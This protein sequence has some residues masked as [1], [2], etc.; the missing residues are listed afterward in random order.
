MADYVNK[1]STGHITISK[2][3]IL[4]FVAVGLVL[5]QSFHSPIRYNP[6]YPTIIKNAASST[7][8][9]CASFGRVG[10]F[11]TYHTNATQQ[12]DEFMCHLNTIRNNVITLLETPEHVDIKLPGHLSVISEATGSVEHE[13]DIRSI[14]QRAAILK[15][16]SDLVRDFSKQFGIAPL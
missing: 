8:T 14:P 7:N 10:D 2:W 5:M 15:W 3:F 13:L 4:V 16:N 1:V 12:L 9:G 11:R 6:S